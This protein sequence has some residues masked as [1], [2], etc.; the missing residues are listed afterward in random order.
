[1]TTHRD[2]IP[3]TG[4]RYE[5]S[6]YRVRFVLLALALAALCYGFLGVG[7]AS[8][9]AQRRTPRVENTVSAALYCYDAARAD[10]DHYSGGQ[11]HRALVRRLMFKGCLAAFRHG[12]CGSDAQCAAFFG[13]EY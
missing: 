12:H 7:L 1:M 8:A 3:P 5:R 6:L 10:S 2:C 4:G 9:N 11:E 13:S